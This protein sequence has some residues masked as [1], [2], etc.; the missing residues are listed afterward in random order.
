M[1]IN[2]SGLTKK[3]KNNLVLDNISLNLEKGKVYAVVG[4]NGAGKSTLFNIIADLIQP[5][6]GFIKYDN[7]VYS[8][9]PST[10]KASMGFMTDVTA[11]IDELTAYQYLKLVG[12]FYNLQKSICI[13]RIE[14]LLRLFFSNDKNILKKIIKSYSTGMRKKLEMCGTCLHTPD[15][16]MLD[17]PFTALDP[18]SAEGV[19]ELITKYKRPYRTILFSSHSLEYIERLDP[20]L[21]LLDEGIIKFKGS[22]SEFKKDA[23]KKFHERFLEELHYHKVYEDI[24]WL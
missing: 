7:S 4:K 11:L 16:L 17:E 8:G 19:I 23:D 6:S 1:E 12:Q 24:K 2:I 5:S 20:V 22:V 10:I 15:F 13:T 14:D 3:Y 9:L 18:I 21:I